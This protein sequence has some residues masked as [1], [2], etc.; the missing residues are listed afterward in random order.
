[1]KTLY[2]GDGPHEI[3]S[4]PAYWSPDGKWIAFGNGGQIYE[5]GDGKIRKLTRDSMWNG[6]PAWSPSY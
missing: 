2:L 4:S 5:T 6:Q 3:V 1:V